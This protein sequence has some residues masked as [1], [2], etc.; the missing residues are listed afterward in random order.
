MATVLNVVSG[1]LKLLEIKVSESALT[2]EEGQDGLVSLND[3]MAEWSEDGIDI[4]YEELDDTDD[5]LFVNAGSLGAIKSN[6]AMYIAPEYGRLVSP[7]LE[8]R[9]EN[10][11]KALRA[12]IPLNPA[13]YPDTLPIGSGNE[14]N[15]FTS[16]GDSPGNLFSRRFYPSN[17]R[18]K[19]N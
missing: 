18:R 14:E 9:A 8:A 3:M 6:L 13:Q 15:N 7:M 16:D 12:S 4:G 1:A 2:A 17:K 5:E 19:C 10:G 11:K